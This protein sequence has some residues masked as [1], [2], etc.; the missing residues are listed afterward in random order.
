MEQEFLGRT[1]LKVSQLCLGTMSFGGSTDEQTAHSMLDRFVDAGGT[2]IDSADVY[3]AGRSEE[4]VGRWLARRSRDELVVATKAYG[5]M[6]SGP[7]DAGAGRKHL[8]SAAEASLRRLQTDYIDLYQIHVFDDATP[9]EE[10]LATLDGL[11]RSGKVRFLGASNYA[12]WQLQKSID[13]A[14]YRGWEPFACLQPLYN[15][16]DR[17]TEWDLLPICRNE[18][19]GL[20]PWSPL[21]GGW[22]AG[23]YRRGMTE[24]PAGSRV[25]ADPDAGG[26][27]EAWRTYA[28]DRTWDVIDTL[29]E[30]AEKTGRSPAQVALRWLIQQPGVTAPIIG[31]RTPEQL[32]DN[33]AAADGSLPEE[34]IERLTAVSDRRAPYPFGLLERFRRR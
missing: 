31:A 28:N 32:E 23:R 34:Y 16:L 27:P 30:V 29:V 5:D 20:I 33:L 12:G 26:W 10:T 18:G 1:G 2:F 19:V 25:D 24:P 8:L 11:V 21:R 7:N 15:L 3:G 17:E 6:G 13:L 14:R 22:L 9:I 4:I